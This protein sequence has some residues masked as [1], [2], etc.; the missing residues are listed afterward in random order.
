MIIQGF[1][2]GL[3]TRQIDWLLTELC[4]AASSII[5]I[6]LLLSHAISLRLA[7]LLSLF[8]VIENMFFAGYSR[9][10]SLE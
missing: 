8:Q 7:I 4:P 3:G 1:H 5:Y 10:I 9:R 2:L 6:V